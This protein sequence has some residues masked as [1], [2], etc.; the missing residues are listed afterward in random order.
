MIN[1]EVKV[2][3][4]KGLYDNEGMC[5]TL[6]SD[7]NE[8]VKAIASGQYLQFCGKVTEMTVKL[9]NLKNGIHNDMES[10]NKTIEELKQINQSLLEQLNGNPA[11]KD[12]VDNGVD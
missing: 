12:G 2:N 9:A 5:G 10:K 3:D 6:V 8:A 11:E 4:G 7:L 1:K